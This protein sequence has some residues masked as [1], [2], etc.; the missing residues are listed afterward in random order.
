[1]KKSSALG[2]ISVSASALSFII[3]VGYDL[4]GF[5]L[6]D[7]FLPV[8]I[9]IKSI[10]YFAL[11]LLGIGFI[12]AVISV[13]FKKVKKTL[14]LL[15][16]SIIALLIGSTILI[17]NVEKKLA[18]EEIIVE[19]KEP[20]KQFPRNDS[21]YIVG[22]VL[23]DSSLS[24]SPVADTAIDHYK[25]TDLTNCMENGFIKMYGVKKAHNIR[26][27]DILFSPD[28]KLLAFSIS[29]IGKGD[30]EQVWILDLK[31]KKCRLVTELVSQEIDLSFY[32]IGWESEGLLKIYLERFYLPNQ[33]L[34]E[35][36]V[37]LASIDKTTEIY[38]TVPKYFE[39]DRSANYYKPYSKYY[40]LSCPDH[41]NKIELLDYRNGQ[42]HYC[43]G[44]VDSQDILTKDLKWTPN[45]SQFVFMT[46]FIHNECSLYIGVTSPQ[47]RIFELINSNFG[48]TYDVSPYSSEIAYAKGFD[49]SLVIYDIFKQKIVHNVQTGVYP[50]KISWGKNKV[51]AFVSTKMGN[52]KTYIDDYQRLYLVEL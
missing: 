44:I 25:Y 27:E 26:Y 17:I 34:N 39:N 43:N 10:L 45:D 7:K 2:I 18:A 51:I 37:L 6:R 12:T 31:S 41:K 11:V 15:A 23:Y 49:S 1:M 52:T 48:L 33:S 24:K 32:H 19:L 50:S 13:F 47:F 20:V 28:G 30:P 29:G 16:L 3:L 46:N 9:L 42:K 40:H 22:A 35:D 38:E 21:L 5:F 4:A 8:T 36:K 14:P